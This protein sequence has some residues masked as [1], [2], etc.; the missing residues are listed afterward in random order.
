MSKR[1]SG[2]P[3]KISTP[4]VALIL[5]GILLVATAL[6]FVLGGGNDGGGT[7]RLAVDQEKI[8]YGDVHF[9]ALARHLPSR[10]PTTVMGC[11]ASKRNHISRCWRAADLLT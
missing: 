3:Q 4:L 7:P 10:S 9:L 11:S 2:Q 5:G 1:K 8:D 6:F